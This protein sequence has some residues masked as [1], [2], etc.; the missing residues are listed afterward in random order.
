M[1]LEIG[2]DGIYVD[3]RSVTFGD[4]PSLRPPDGGTIA[5]D[6]LGAA[7]FTWP[8]G[9]LFVV[10]PTQVELAQRLL[11]TQPSVSEIEQVRVQPCQR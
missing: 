3:D 11:V 1:T 4:L 7:R 10:D 8:D 5:I 6:E 9:T 2:V